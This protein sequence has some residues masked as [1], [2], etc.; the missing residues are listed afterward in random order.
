MRRAAVAALV[1]LA[2]CWALTFAARPWSDERVSDLFVYR[3]TAA[4]LLHGSLPY[5][6][7]AFEY[8]PLAAGVIALPGAVLASASDEN[9]YRLAF[10]VAML[11]CA[12]A[13]LLLTGALARATGG[14]PR[15]AM[16]A[17]ALAPLLT[18]AMV[19]THF[20]LAP[21]AL[22]LAALLCLCRGRPAAGLALLGLGVMTKGFPLVVA[23]VAL[24]WLVACGQR[25]AA[26]RGAAALAA[27]MALIGGLALAASPAGALDAVRY[28]VD[29]PVQ[30]ESAPAYVLRALDG[31]GLGE[32]RPVSSFRSDGLL[33]PASRGV[34]AAFALALLAAL[35]T[36]AYA[37]ARGP[38]RPDER[39]LVFAALAAVAAFAA[40]GKVLSPQF[41]VW[42]VP[43]GALALAWRMYGLALL[44]AAAVGLT[45]VEFPSRYF[46]LVAGARFPV[47][48]VGVRDALLLA[49]VGA[50]LARL[51]RA[52]SDGGQKYLLDGG[53]TAVG[54]GVDQH[55][56]Q[57]RVFV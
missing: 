52:D 22:T 56:V 54:T 42:I 25:P 4:T 35:A 43:L 53:G 39:S 47:A 9:A 51:W 18:G 5:R 6:D 11:A 8:P 36:L 57:P 20:D 16:A 12:V 28:H 2:A 48:V 30:V 40:L 49:L 44:A 27:T 31:A 3:S 41:M 23:P 38:T 45:L 7:V 1:V 55:G 19:R 50:A 26:V 24:A 29:R 21:V 10:A 17:V 14:D 37:A 34:Q 33:H 15:L 32:A 13:V 46:D